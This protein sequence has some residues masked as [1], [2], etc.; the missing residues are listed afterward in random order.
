MG[1]KM[2]FKEK[3]RKREVCMMK[4]L[5]MKEKGLGKKEEH[6]RVGDVRHDRLEKQAIYACY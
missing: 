6:P 5:E 3:K 2:E 1:E 4:L